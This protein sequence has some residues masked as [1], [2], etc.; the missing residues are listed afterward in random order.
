MDVLDSSAFIND[1]TTDEEIVS[2]P[3]VREELE[4]SASYRFDALE[5]SGMTLHVPSPD[6]VSRVE[7]AARETGDL[8]VLSETD[9][10][11]IATA[12]ELDARLVTD[13]YAMQNVASKLDVAVEVIAQEGIDQQLDWDYQCQGCGRTFDEHHERCVICG[14]D[15]ERKN[16]A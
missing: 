11:L 14:S 7:R 2:I 10:R 13:D 3:M 5:G 1:Y 4:D 8:E 6:N 16:P 15:L 12:Y 9:I